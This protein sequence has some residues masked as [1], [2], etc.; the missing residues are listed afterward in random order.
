MLQGSC[1][2]GG[3][4]YEIDGDLEIGNYTGLAYRR[5]VLAGA[6]APTAGHIRVDGEATNVAETTIR[7]RVG[8]ESP[9]AIRVGRPQVNR[10]G[11]GGTTA[12][13]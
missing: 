10:P 5:P 12:G 2:C 4:R 13:K 9:M 11:T 3:I 6:L 1:L 7:G 8:S